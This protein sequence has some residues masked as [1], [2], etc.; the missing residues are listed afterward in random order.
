M[1]F[2]PAARPAFHTRA[3]RGVS[4]GL[5][6][7]TDAI[8]LPAAL[9]RAGLGEVVRFGRRRWWGRRWSVWVEL[10]QVMPWGV[11]CPAALRAGHVVRLVVAD[12]LRYVHEL[13]ALL[14]RAIVPARRMVA[15]REG[16]DS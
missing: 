12:L 3:W 16:Q 14:D 10:M 7:K 15:P 8:L 13:I 1:R 5:K 11:H 2:E 6:E 9:C 4:V